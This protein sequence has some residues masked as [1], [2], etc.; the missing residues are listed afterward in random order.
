MSARVSF[1]RI[2]GDAYYTPDDVAAACVRTIAPRL[3]AGDPLLIIEPSVGGGAFVRAVNAIGLND[4][5]AIDINGNAAGLGL[6]TTYSVGDFA[7]LDIEPPA[8][9]TW[10]IGNPPYSH[11]QRHVERAISLAM[12]ERGESGG[13]GFL[14]RLAFLEGKAR[15]PF[16]RMYPPTEVHILTRRPS[17]TG[18]KT[19]SCAYA[20]FVWCAG[21]RQPVGWIP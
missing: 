11:A 5:Y 13:V 7:A 8:C 1:P 9:R 10:V 19:D 2:E 3:L 15:A 4:T 12:P 6:A 14:L 21:E 16:W 20:F 17:F 18:G